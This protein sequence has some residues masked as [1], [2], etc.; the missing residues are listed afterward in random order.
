MTTRDT[1]PTGEARRRLAAYVAAA[2]SGPGSMLID[3]I[4]ALLAGYGDT[5]EGQERGGPVAKAE[6][7]ERELA[8]RD[9]DWILAMGHALG[10]D[11][12]FSIPIV[13]TVEQFKLLFDAVAARGAEGQE[14]G[15]PTWDAVIRVVEAERVRC[16]WAGEM[17]PQ[18]A[19]KTRESDKAFHDVLG[20]LRFAR[21]R[22]ITSSLAAARGA[23][24]G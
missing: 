9:R 20:S 22:G 14:R 11:S 23:D 19:C 2:A 16:K 15:G 6:E 8:N 4:R 21:D 10:L 24:N 3:D 7:S 17:F 13:P 5:A 1:T 18:V 12:G